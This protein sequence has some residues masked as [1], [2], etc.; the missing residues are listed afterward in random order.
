[1]SNKVKRTLLQNTKYLNTFR[2]CVDSCNTAHITDFIL[3]V[4][5]KHLSSKAFVHDILYID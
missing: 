2:M 5:T 4:V 1:M 3:W